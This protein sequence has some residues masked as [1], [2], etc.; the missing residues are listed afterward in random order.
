MTGIKNFDSIITSQPIRLKQGAKNDNDGSFND[1]SNFLENVEIIM[2]KQK[3][4]LAS[5]RTYVTLAQILQA[6]EISSKHYLLLAKKCLTKYR[7]LKYSDL[8][9]YIK[10]VS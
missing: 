1:T 3:M 9:V 7:L 10:M 6:N 5:A 4:L 8:T 2:S